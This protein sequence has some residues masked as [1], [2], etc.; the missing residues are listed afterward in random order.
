MQK[1]KVP[2][3]DEQMDGNYTKLHKILTVD[4]KNKD[5]RQEVKAK[6]DERPEN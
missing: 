5:I 4:H 6:L 2:S 1:T 3:F